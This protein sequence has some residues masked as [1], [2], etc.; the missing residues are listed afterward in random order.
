MSLEETDTLAVYNAVDDVSHGM[1]SRH[2]LNGIAIVLAEYLHLTPSISLD[3]LMNDMRGAITTYLLEIRREAGTQVVADIENWHRVIGRFGRSE[4]PERDQL[5]RLEAELK[6]IDV[7]TPPSEP[8]GNWKLSEETERSL[9]EID[10]NLKMGKAMA[11]DFIV[12]SASEPAGVEEIA[13]EC[14]E[15]INVLNGL[16]EETPPIIAKHIRRAI[17]SVERERDALKEALRIADE[18]LEPIAPSAPNT[19]ALE[20]ILW[21]HVDDEDLAT[22]SM[23]VGMFRKVRSVRAQIAALSSTRQE[24]EKS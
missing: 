11:K 1:P 24:E 17:A 23:K 4:K 10:D 22:V 3:K 14:A 5:A 21:G 7:A 15:E 13:R 2:V 20:E 8:A 18:A 9:R 12:G 6:Q 19:E 16:C